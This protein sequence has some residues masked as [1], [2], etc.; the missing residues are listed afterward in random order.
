MRYRGL[1]RAHAQSMM[2]LNA[3]LLRVTC[4]LEVEIV[5]VCLGQ[6]LVQDCLHVHLLDDGIIQ[7]LQPVSG[8]SPTSL[9]ERQKGEM[10]SDDRPRKEIRARELSPSLGLVQVR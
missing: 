3:Q 5:P 6:L 8:F 9:A 7:E 2:P 10:S 1:R 4:S